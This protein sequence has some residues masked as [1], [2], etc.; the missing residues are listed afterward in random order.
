MKRSQPWQEEESTDLAP[1]VPPVPKAGKRAIAHIRDRLFHQQRTR[2]AF[3]RINEQVRQ[4]L[5]AQLPTQT[6]EVHYSAAAFTKGARI[7]KSGNEPP[8]GYKGTPLMFTQPT[9]TVRGFLKRDAVG[10]PQIS[11]ETQA[12]IIQ[13]VSVLL[14]HLWVPIN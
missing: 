7:A 13:G 2:S 10:L 14:K 6:E 9:S 12:T 8:S 5:Q 3:A 11:R 4:A 1:N